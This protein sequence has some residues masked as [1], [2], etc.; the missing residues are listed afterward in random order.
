MGNYGE[1]ATEISVEKVPII[2]SI[3]FT[4]KHYA[5]CLMT[6]MHNLLIYLLEAMNKMSIFKISK[7]DDRDLQNITS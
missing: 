2:R 1:A 3:R 7:T 6:M 4:N 5:F